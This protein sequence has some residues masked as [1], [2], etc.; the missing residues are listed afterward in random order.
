M[1]G[2]ISIAVLC[3][4]SLYLDALN[5]L[6]MTSGTKVALAQDT[7]GHSASLG[8]QILRGQQETLGI[9]VAQLL[10]TYLSVMGTH[11]K[12]INISNDEI[13]QHI[14]KAKEKEKAKITGRLGDMTVEE[15]EVEDLLKNHRLGDWGLGQTRALFEYDPEQY[16][17]ERAAL[18]QD[19]LDELKV[20]VMDGVTERNRDI[21]RMEHL[22][23]EATKAQVAG[24]QH[25]AM[26]ALPD[27]D[28]YGDRDGDEAF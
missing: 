10:G 3:A 5:E 22:E 6:P 2:T 9:K 24:E 12:L 20:G 15:R 25:A 17:K 11:K 7:A 4:L 21:Y 8:D 26:L 13:K 27:D 1:F 14:L 19:A 28:D 23:E 18:E 16:D